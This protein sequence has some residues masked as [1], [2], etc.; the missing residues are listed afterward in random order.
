[1]IASLS[2]IPMSLGPKN[3]ALFLGPND[4]GI[5]EREAIKDIS[6]LFSRYNDVIMARL[7]NHQ[8]IIELAEYSDI[9]VINGLTDYN[10]PCQI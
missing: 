4:I 9:P 1:M 2:P 5:G 10:H 3:S 7:F 6:R 8:H